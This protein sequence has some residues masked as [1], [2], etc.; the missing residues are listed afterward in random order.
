MRHGTRPSRRGDQ[1]FVR[2]SQSVSITGTSSGFGRLAARKFRHEGWSVAATMRS[3]A[4]ERSHGRSSGWSFFVSTRPAPH[5]WRQ[6]SRRRSTPSAPCTCSSTTPGSASAGCSSSTTRT[7]FGRSTRR[8]RHDERPP[9]CSP[10]R[11][12]ARR[13]HRQRD[14]GRQLDGRPGHPALERLQVSA[15][16]FSESLSMDYGAPMASGCGPLLTARSRPDSRLPPTVRLGS[17]SPRTRRYDEQPQRDA[18]RKQD[19]D[20]LDRVSSARVPITQ[21]RKKSNIERHCAV[22]S[23]RH[24]DFVGRPS[25]LRTHH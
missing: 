5:R 14:I 22:A 4:Q 17:A 12:A 19:A 25:T 20:P 6:P 11:A 15:R 3:P 10:T 1:E 16:G 2:R 21:S 18:N 9:P 7:R 13:D 8:R 24:N 23:L